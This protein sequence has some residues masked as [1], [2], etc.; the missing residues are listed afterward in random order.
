MEDEYFSDTLRDKLIIAG[1][2]EISQYG[3]HNFSLRRVATACNISCAAPYKHFKNKEDF[4]LEIIRYIN[5]QWS[6][7]RDQ[8]LTLFT[9]DIRKQLV[10][11][12]IAYVRFWVANPNYRSVLLASEKE[13]E[14]AEKSTSVE[15]L[16][17]TY[18]ASNGDDTDETERTVYAIKAILYGMTAMM[19]NGE[20]Q[21]IPKTYEHIRVTIE[22]ELN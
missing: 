13:L 1:A 16:I 6:L 10:E 14:G 9:G 19:E 18:C 3:I 15:A 8:I 22:K 2:D 21:N 4:I 5:R 7:L 11:V 17:R 12:C 20:L